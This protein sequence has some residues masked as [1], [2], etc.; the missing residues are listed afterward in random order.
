MR[1]LQQ[2]RQHGIRPGH[3]SDPSSHAHYGYPPPLPVIGSQDPRNYSSHDDPS[4]GRSGYAYDH[5]RTSSAYSNPYP[6]PPPPGGYQYGPGPS[7]RRVDDEPASHPRGLVGDPYQGYETDSRYGSPAPS[8]PL[9]P[10]TFGSMPF[11]PSAASPVL[12]LP[13][14]PASNGF[15]SA[16]GFSQS[17]R[18]R[19]SLSSAP[20]AQRGAYANGPPGSNYYS[21]S[22]Y[23]P[24]TSSDRYQSDYQ[25]EPSPYAAPYAQGPPAERYQDRR[26]SDESNGDG[27]GTS[28]GSYPPPPQAYAHHQAYE[29]HRLHS[30]P[31]GYEPRQALPPPVAFGEA[32]VVQ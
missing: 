22:N 32:A 20:P 13:V 5:S 14:V 6:P 26:R 21:Q 3:P 4:D 17:A 2:S 31:G 19:P 1:S 28:Q 30:E 16:P 24:G 25:S 9:R 10:L 29:Q 7:D 11:Q 15:P 8:A 12:S 23:L 18:F 27:S